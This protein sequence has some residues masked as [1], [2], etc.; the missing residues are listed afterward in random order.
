MCTKD[1]WS[2]KVLKVLIRMANAPKIVQII[3]ACELSEPILHYIL[4]NKSRVVSW[5]TM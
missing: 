4:I 1:L 5:T 2:G 3:Q